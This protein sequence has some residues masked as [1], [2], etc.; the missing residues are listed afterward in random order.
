MYPCGNI[1]NLRCKLINMA[2][3]VVVGGALLI[4]AGNMTA[5]RPYDWLTTPAQLWKE[6]HPGS[7]D[8][9]V[10]YRPG[11]RSIQFQ[12]ENPNNYINSETSRRQA[13]ALN[14][15]HSSNPSLRKVGVKDVMLNQRRWGSGVIGLS[16]PFS[17]T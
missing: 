16:T 9:T 8:Y 5:A 1:I 14:A 3:A 2:F 6:A 11:I 7:N 4:T 15:T 10:N 12:V 17:N 13:L